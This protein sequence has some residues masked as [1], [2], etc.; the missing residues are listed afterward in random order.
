MA[1]GVLR[2][3]M[4]RPFTLPRLGFAGGFARCYV[5]DFYIILYNGFKSTCYT[6]KY[7]R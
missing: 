1:V 4:L 2:G 6:P 5:N 7:L 3:G